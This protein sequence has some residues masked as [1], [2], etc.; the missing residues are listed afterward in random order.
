VG[1]ISKTTAIIL[2]TEYH[3]SGMSTLFLWYSWLTVSPPPTPIFKEEEYKK[4]E[5]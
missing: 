5:Y 1:N 2:D 4:K 3:C